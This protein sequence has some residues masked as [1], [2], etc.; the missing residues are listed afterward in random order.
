M[1]RKEVQSQGRNYRKGEDNCLH[2]MLYAG[3]KR[4]SP[5]PTGEW[6]TSQRKTYKPEEDHRL[7]KALPDFSVACL[8]NSGYSEPLV[9]DQGSSLPGKGR[10]NPF[11]MRPEM[12]RSQGG[13]DEAAFFPLL[14]NSQA[15]NSDGF[16]F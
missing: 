16:Y 3:N 6:H 8:D 15:I 5:R 10:N 2:Y 1:S 14:G 7:S 4:L 13:G 11:I 12:A 9:T